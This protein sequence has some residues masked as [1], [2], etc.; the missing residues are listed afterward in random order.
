MDSIS[1][2]LM[3]EMELIFC[4]WPTSSPVVLNEVD[5]DELLS[6]NM[7][8]PSTTY[9]GFWA[10]RIL[11]SKPAPGVPEGEVTLMP[12]S[13]PWMLPARLARGWFLKSLLPMDATAPVR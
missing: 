12:D 5:N 10:P 7:G 8:M 1:L 13:L 11:T 3:S 6:L 2:G 9:K 4:P